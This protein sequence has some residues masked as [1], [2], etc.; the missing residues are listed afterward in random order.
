MRLFS[1]AGK[2]RFDPLVK[3]RPLTRPEGS[4]LPSPLGEGSGF[5]WYA[6]SRAP[7]EASPLREGSGFFPLLRDGSDF[8]RRWE[9]DPFRE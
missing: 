6:G 7:S 3:K 8:V 1:G 5:F 4:G 2:K 9:R